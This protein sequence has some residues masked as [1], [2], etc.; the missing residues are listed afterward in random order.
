VRGRRIRVG[1][2]AGK[3]DLLRP[4]RRNAGRPQE[5]SDSSDWIPYIAHHQV[6]DTLAPCLSSAATSSRLE[7]RWSRSRGVV[8]RAQWVKGKAVEDFL[9]RLPA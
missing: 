2:E 8:E 9:H 5:D 7:V 3:A 6:I 4:S 1:K